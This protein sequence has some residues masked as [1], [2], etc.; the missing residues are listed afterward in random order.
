MPNIT[1]VIWD[2]DGTLLDT[3]PP[4]MAA[5]GAIAARY[6]QEFTVDVRERMMGRPSPVAARIFVET[7]GIPLTPDQFLV[8]RDTAL[9]ILFRDCPPM[10]GALSLSAHL[11]RHTIPQAIATSS[12]RV[13]L[14]QKTVMHAEWFAMFAAVVTGDEVAHGKPA[15]D[16]FLRAAEQIGARPEAT[17]VFEDSPLGVEAARAAGMHVVAVPE[18][19]FRDHVRDADT[20]LDSLEAFDPAPWGLPAFGPSRA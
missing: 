15:P 14:L 20:V 2:L 16:I 10:P 8:E 18:A 4:Y 7:L 5:I 6:G 12:S 11:H 1:H 9:A 3:E 13:T 19:V 17:L